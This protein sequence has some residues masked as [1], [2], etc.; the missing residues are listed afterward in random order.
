MLEKKYPRLPF[1]PPAYWDVLP[2]MLLLLE[3]DPAGHGEHSSSD[4]LVAPASQGN[5]ARSAVT[6]SLS[7]QNLA[8]ICV[9]PVPVALWYVS[10]M[11]TGVGCAACARCAPRLARPPLTG[12]S[13]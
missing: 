4:D 12:G 10:I 2:A 1:N 7:A 11:I 9:L 8:L 6:L 3:K 5:Q 13:V